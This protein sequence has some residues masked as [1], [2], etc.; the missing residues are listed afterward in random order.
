MHW[1]DIYPHKIWTNILVIDNKIIDYK[2]GVN[3]LDKFSWTIRFNEELHDRFN[4][5]ETISTF[6]L[7]NNGVEHERAFDNGSQ[8]VKEHAKMHGYYTYE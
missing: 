4:E 2:I 8:L 1:S 5:I 3:Q 6:E 7:V